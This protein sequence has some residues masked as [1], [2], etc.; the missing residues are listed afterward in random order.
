VSIPFKLSISHYRNPVNT[1][2]IAGFSLTT[3]DSDGNLINVSEKELLLLSNLTET[4]S[5][6]ERE[7]VMLG[8]ANGSNIG[9]IGTY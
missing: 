1:R 8:D 4:A 2:P 5:I 3:L 7:M 6:G 9:R